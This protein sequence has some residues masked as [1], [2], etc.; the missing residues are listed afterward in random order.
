MSL[1]DFYQFC[2]KSEVEGI[3]LWDLHLPET[4]SRE[5]IGGTRR[6]LNAVGL[7]LATIA[8]NNHKFTSL[9][10]SERAR[11][12]AK[13]RRWIDVV[14]SL[15][16]SV[17]RV[18]AGELKILN[19]HR[20]VRYPLVR[21]AFEECLAHAQARGVTLAVEN[22]PREAHPGVVLDLVKDLNT[23]FLRAC[24]DIGNS[25]QA[26][27][28]RAWE[29]AAPFAVHVHAKT[30]DFDERGEETTIDYSRAMAILRKSGYKGYVSVEFEGDGDEVVGVQKS[31][32]LVSQYMHCGS[33]EW[34]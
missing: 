16:C 22:C 23:P 24:P 17:L 10:A 20:A 3:E 19:T 13:I 32:A 8:V 31:I 14:N 9:V 26:V 6:E 27:R 28:Y 30:F 11:E 29:E 2:Q 4:P 21:A 1:H 34:T 7:P 25:P 12:V 18:L 15:D 33:A 5:F